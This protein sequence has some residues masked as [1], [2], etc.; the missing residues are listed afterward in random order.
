MPQFDQFDPIQ[1]GTLVNISSGAP[2]WYR[3]DWPASTVPADIYARSLEIGVVLKEHVPPS[4]ERSHDRGLWV[5]VR[6]KEMLIFDECLEP[7]STESEG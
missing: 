4:H 5:L 3:S 1:P 6:G 7:I 2:M